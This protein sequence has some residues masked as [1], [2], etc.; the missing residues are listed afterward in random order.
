[1]THEQ[2]AARMAQLVA[3]LE[4][5]SR[6]YYVDA[7][8]EI[9]DAAFDRMLRELADLEKAYPDLAFE[10]SPTRRV[11]GEPLKGFV[12]IAHPERMLSLDNSYSEAEVAEF[13]QRVA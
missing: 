9:S 13:F 7:R 3:E 6:L 5:H 10:N 4:R 8:P 11:G 2:A 1:M 12:Q